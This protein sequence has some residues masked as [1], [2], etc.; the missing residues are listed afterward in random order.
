VAVWTARGGNNHFSEKLPAVERA[1]RPR[2]EREGMAGWPHE[3]AKARMARF[4]RRPL[5]IP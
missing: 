2:V 4:K 5:K 3:V 1:E